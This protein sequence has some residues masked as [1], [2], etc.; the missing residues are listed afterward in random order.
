MTAYPSPQPW[1]QAL[2]RLPL[3]IGRM[4]LVLLAAA[5]AAALVLAGA[6]LGLGVLAWARL[7]GRPVLKVQRFAWRRAA[8][9][10]GAA[11]ARDVVDVQ[12]RELHDAPPAPVSVERLR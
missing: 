7:R 4:L 6:V 3:R 8:P 2:L 11:D 5:F 1:W 9:R 10:S 12:A